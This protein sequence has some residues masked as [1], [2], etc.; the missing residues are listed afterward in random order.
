ME[1]IIAKLEDK[2]HFKLARELTKACEDKVESKK[3]WGTLPKGWTEQSLEK[4]AR[5]LTKKNKGDSEGFVRACVKKLSGTGISSPE[6][7]CSSLKDR[8]LGKKTWRKGRK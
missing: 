6:A 2:G 4:F 8:Y 7:F 3:P 1:R 5:S